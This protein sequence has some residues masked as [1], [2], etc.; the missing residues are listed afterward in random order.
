M[1]YIIYLALLYLFLPFNRLFD[2]I[3]VMLFFIIFN[4]NEW[5]AI[6][7]SFF[8]GFLIDLYIPTF[9]GLHAL[10]YT[11]LAQVLL[12]VKRFVAKD[13]ITVLVAFAVFFLLKVILVTVVTG[14]PITAAPLIL[15]VMTC[16]PLYLMANKLVFHTWMRH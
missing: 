11:I 8:A 13:L 3:A 10:T 9:L 5:F 7:F 2:L 12:Y 4:E 14:S 15:T 16:L 1:R 6:I